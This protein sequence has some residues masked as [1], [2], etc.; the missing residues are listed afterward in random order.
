MIDEAKSGKRMTRQEYLK[1]HF[2]LLPRD[3]LPGNDIAFVGWK[4]MKWHDKVEQTADVSW[5]HPYFGQLFWKTHQEYLL[6]RGPAKP[7]HPWYFVNF[8][9]N[10]GGPQSISNVQ[11]IFA[12]TCL[13]L[14]IKPPHHPH[15]L[16]HLYVDTLV[17]VCG[18]PLHQAQVLV[19][20]RSPASTE[21]YAMASLEATRL[22][23]LALAKKLL[24][25]PGG[26]QWAPGAASHIQSPL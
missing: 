21:V 26:E 15:A 3:Q 2:N 14:G 24:E 17:N 5:L 4:G 25:L 8:K 10:I 7:L 23:L 11:A 13:R 9:A 16:R 6:L 12:S 20:H 18:L 1:K 22:A 19:R